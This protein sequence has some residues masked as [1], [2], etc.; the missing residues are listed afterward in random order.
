MEARPSLIQYSTLRALMKPALENLSKV[1]TYSLAAN[2]SPAWL[3][4]PLLSVAIIQTGPE[5]W[6]L[7]AHTDK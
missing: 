5:I 6:N 1:T 4:A 2:P 7:E 3:V